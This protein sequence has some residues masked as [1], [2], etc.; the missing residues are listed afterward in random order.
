[1]NRA[2]SLRIA[3]ESDAS[4]ILSIYAPYVEKTAITFE[5]EVPT[6][7]EFK[8]RIHNTL[9][10][11]P[12]LAALD[13]DRIVGY[14]YAG[15]F[16]ARAAYQWS[17]ETSIYIDSAYKRRGIG[18]MLQSALEA[19]LKMQ[20][21]LNVN[22]CIAYPENDDPYLTKDSF[23]FHSKCGFD[24]VG[25]FHNCGY[26]FHRWYHAVWMEKMI[27]E[28][29]ADQTPF[30]TFPEICAALSDNDWNCILHHC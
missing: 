21:I 12:Y 6:L 30:R 3:K 13:G 10:T 1:M 23:Y 18:Q 14:A 29:H 7:L 26:K 9:K 17:V 22:A 19:I 25:I 11:Y 16:K 4:A 8:E 27:G 2:I 15:A 24:T 28:H 20:G 5:Y